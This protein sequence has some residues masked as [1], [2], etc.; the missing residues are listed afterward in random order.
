MKK[1]VIYIIS[2]I[3]I[4]G[5]LINIVFLFSEFKDNISTI[6][7]YDYRIAIFGNNGVYP[8]EV[9]TY[10]QNI[11]GEIP[12]VTIE[13]VPIKFDTEESFIMC[14]ALDDNTFKNLYSKS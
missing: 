10:A 5:T 2:A 6:S 13:A 4:F 9:V 3:L 7:A 11:A 8:E 12:N 14:I 1:Y